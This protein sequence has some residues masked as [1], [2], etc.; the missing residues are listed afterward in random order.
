MN[1]QTQNS[2]GTDQQARLTSLLLYCP[3]CHTETRHILSEVVR[4][5][6][7]AEIEHYM[8]TRCFSRIEPYTVR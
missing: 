6:K 5:R 2:K 8:C 3:V 4:T 1:T 7:G